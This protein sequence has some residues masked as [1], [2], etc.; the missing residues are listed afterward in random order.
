MTDPQF[1]QQLTIE[2]KGGQTIH[3][4]FNIEKPGAINPQIDAFIKAVGDPSKRDFS[5][6]FKGAQV[7]LVR[8]EDV[9]AVQIVSLVRKDEEE[10]AGA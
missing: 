6:V 10:G 7:V 8:L 4:P 9:S 2:L 3:V 5:F 1:L